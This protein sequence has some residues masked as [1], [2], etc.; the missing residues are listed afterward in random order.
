MPKVCVVTLYRHNYGAFLQAYALQRF[1]ERAGFDAELL[2]YDYYN[3]HA[4]LGISVKRLR[5]PVSFAKAVAFRLSR[6]GAFRERE[7]AIARCVE[8]SLRES[9]FYQTYR[10]V[11]KH[12]PQADIYMTGSDQVWNPTISEQGFLSRLLDFAPNE[13]NVLCSYAASA[14]VSAFSS[15]TA[16]LMRACLARFDTISVREPATEKVIRP[17]TGRE[18][19]LHRDPVFLLSAGDWDSFAEGI[20][21]ER[22]YIFIYLAQK[23]PELVRYAIDLSEKT[24]YGIVD[25]HGSINY[26]I[27]NCANGKRVLSPT[28]FVGGIK[29][30]AYVVTNS[31]HCLAFS[32]HYHKKAYIKLPPKGAG[33]LSELIDGMSLQRLLQPEPIRDGEEDGIYAHTADFLR[34]GQ[35]AA[36]NY[37]AELSRI[38]AEKRS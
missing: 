34:E 21:T 5:H 19:V 24:G 1:L 30:A 32:I 28:E 8:A 36:R 2:N 33:R 3:D 23:A 7:R 16:A 29:N 13:R 9:A 38:L 26:S 15:Q 4:I 27:P 31:F 14:G 6:R 17:L 37:L 25:C 20:K 12:P 18:I 35:K 11:R 22:P 10:A